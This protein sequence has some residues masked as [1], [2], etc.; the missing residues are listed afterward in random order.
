M[1]GD[2]QASSAACLPEAFD[3]DLASDGAAREKAGGVRERGDEDL[4]LRRGV[5]RW[6]RVGKWRRAAGWI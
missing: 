4:R 2:E 3:E 6:G 5:V 1:G